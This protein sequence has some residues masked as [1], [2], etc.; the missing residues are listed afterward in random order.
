MKQ[1]LNRRP[2]VSSAKAYLARCDAY[3]TRMIP[4]GF[5][6]GCFVL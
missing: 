6:L 3:T 4:Y 1:L 5:S 2:E